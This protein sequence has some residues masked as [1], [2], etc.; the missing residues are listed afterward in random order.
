MQR[1]T[2]PPPV[3]QAP[4]GRNQFGGAIGGPILHDKTF[5]FGDVEFGRI[6]ESYTS[7]NSLPDAAELTGQFP[8]GPGDPV[9]YDP[10]TP[11]VPFPIVNSQYVIPA[12]SIDPISQKVVNLLISAGAD[13]RGATANNFVYASPEDTNAHRW[14]VRV[15]Q[16]LTDKQNLYFRFSSQV[17]DLGIT[18]LLPPARAKAISPTAQPPARPAHKPWTARASCWATTVFGPPPW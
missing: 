3:S 2:S 11:G 1:T 16:I 13:P 14:D 5:F 9:I 6:R 7:V 12:G 15:D 8:A 18:S 10:S 17:D 4:F